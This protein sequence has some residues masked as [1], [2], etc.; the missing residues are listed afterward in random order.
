MEVKFQGATWIWSIHS[1]VLTVFLK[2]ELFRKKND[3]K[4]FNRNWHG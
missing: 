1:Q 3:S 4:D 2:M